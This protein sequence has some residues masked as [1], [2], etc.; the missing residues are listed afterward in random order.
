MFY[1]RK[2]NVSS[3]LPKKPQGAPEVRRAAAEAAEAERKEK[4]RSAELEL[5]KEQ[6]QSK[7]WQGAARQAE[8]ELKELM[9]RL[10]AALYG[11]LAAT[12]SSASPPP[13]ST[14]PE[15]EPE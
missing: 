5:E 7:Y 6:R 11:Q 3:S 12:A 10:E 9:A 4:Q 13:A 14:E 8:K 2:R 15:G 1:P